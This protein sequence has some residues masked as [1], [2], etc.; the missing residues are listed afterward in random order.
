MQIVLRTWNWHVAVSEELPALLQNVY[1]PWVTNSTLNL[2]LVLDPHSQQVLQTP[3][4]LKGV[5]TLQSEA[6]QTHSD[7]CTQTRV[8]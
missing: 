5:C 6:D 3:T 8:T 1:P 4:V 2:C 7:K